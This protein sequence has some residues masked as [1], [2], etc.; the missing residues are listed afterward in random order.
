MYNQKSLNLLNCHWFIKV[1][2]FNGQKSL[3]EC[4]IC[5]M[6]ILQ[7]IFAIKINIEARYDLCV[8]SSIKAFFVCLFC[9]IIL[10]L[11]A[12]RHIISPISPVGY[13]K[14]CSRQQMFLLV[15]VSLSS[16]ISTIIHHLRVRMHLIKTANFINQDIC[17]TINIFEE[18]IF[19]YFPAGWQSSSHYHPC[20]GTYCYWLNVHFIYQWGC[21]W[22]SNIGNLLECRFLKYSPGLKIL[23]QKLWAWD[24][25]ICLNKVSR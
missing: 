11:I 12:K 21:F 15:V 19:M 23:N 3:N 25:E 10:D 13:F 1:C 17:G 24:P 4:N 8:N 9:F 6:N 7:S 22:T 18:K 16:H 20:S 5:E 14:L 2:T